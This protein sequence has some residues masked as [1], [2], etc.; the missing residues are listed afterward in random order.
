M[1]VWFDNAIANTLQIDPLVPDICIR[2]NV[3]ES[4]VAVASLSSGFM[5][6][7]IDWGDEKKHKK[8]INIKSGTSYSFDHAYEEAGTYI[9]VAKGY[10]RRLNADRTAWEIYDNEM[11]TTVK[12]RDN[13]PSMS[14]S[15]ADVD[16]W[17]ED[18][19][20]ESVQFSPTN[21]GECHKVGDYAR[22]LEVASVSSGYMAVV[23]DWGIG[24][25]VKYGFNVDSG[26]P[27]A[28]PFAYNEPGTYHISAT[29]EIRRLSTDSRTWDV[30][31]GTYSM[32][33]IVTEDCSIDT[34][35]NIGNFDNDNDGVD[36]DAEN[37]AGTDSNHPDTDRDGASD[38]EEAIAESDPLDP[39]DTPPIKDIDFDK[40]SNALED[41]MGTNPISP[42]TDG[43]GAR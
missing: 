12:V 43:D 7:S 34:T 42:D 30:Y 33:V 1:N 27:V 15:R 13:C 14:M 17:N 26:T 25:V 28:I 11:T 20:G 22:M 18:T 6:L 35:L 16:I 31:E 10:V 39:T 38:G 5:N 41:I 3:Q 24:S 36:N 9:V 32:E 4:V 37:A 21:P 23:I 19:I 40:V 2:T 8:G 29:A